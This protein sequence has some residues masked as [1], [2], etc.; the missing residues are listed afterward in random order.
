VTDSSLEPKIDPRQS[1]EMPFL[2]HLEELRQT[3]VQVVVACGIGA[4]AGWWLAPR[5]LETLIRRTVGQALVLSPLEAF[6]ERFKLSLLLG[7]M[8]VAPFVFHRIWRFIVPGL[9]HRER[10]LILPMAMGSM[11]L[12][13]LGL[14]AAY[15][16]VVPLVLRVLTNFATPSMNAQ[17]RLSELLGF[18]YNLGIACGLVCQ[19]PLVTMTLTAIGLVTPGALLRQWRYAIVGAF[20][21]TALI[22]PGDVV[23]AQIV[24]GLPMTLLYFLS[25]GLSWLVARRRPKEEPVAMEE[26]ERA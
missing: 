4:I 8:L 13:G 3:L 6:N 26:V 22:T 17:I 21:L 5:V 11:A 23:T 10:S 24:M 20:A 12:F 7:L 15:G 25:V 1:G 14:W 16:Y 19:L 2:A 9:F 18:F